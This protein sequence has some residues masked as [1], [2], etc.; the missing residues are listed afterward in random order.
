M[1]IRIIKEQLFTYN[2]KETK[3]AIIKLLYTFYLH[4]SYLSIMINNSFLLK[5]Y[6]KD[7][8]I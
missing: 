1:Q 3:F 4:C 5:E 7:P 2:M 8:Y 6:Y